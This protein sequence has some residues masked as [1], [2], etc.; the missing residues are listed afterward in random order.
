M[1]KQFLASREE[2]ELAARELSALFDDP[3]QPGTDAGQRFAALIALVDQYET[4]H[5]PID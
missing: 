3:P 4:A 5:F 2:Y 1:N